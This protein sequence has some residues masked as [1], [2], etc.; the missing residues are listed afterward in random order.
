M[1]AGCLVLWLVIPLG[2]LR[3]ASLLSDTGYVVYLV[4]L[5]ACPITMAFWGWALYRLNDVYLRLTGRE[6][7]QRQ[8][9]WL[10]SAT[11]PSTGRR[12]IMLL[13][14]MMVVSVVLAIV[15]LVLWFAVFAASP[16]STPW[17]DEL[18]GGS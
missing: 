18:S 1:A 2:W 8:Q 9:A 5:F 6:R 16:T 17:P 12:E 15:A 13:D 7:P 3:I 4:A 10:E 14:A 11:R